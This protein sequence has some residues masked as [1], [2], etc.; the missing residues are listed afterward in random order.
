MAEKMSRLH[1]IQEHE[2]EIDWIFSE[3]K[4]LQE[5]GGCNHGGPIC[6]LIPQWCSV[7]EQEATCTNWNSGGSIWLGSSS[8]WGWPC[9]QPGWPV[10]LWISN[11]WNIQNLTDTEHSPVQPGLPPHAWEVSLDK[12]ISRGPFQSLQ[13]CDSVK[14]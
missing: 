3:T 12:K 6:V 1:S 11:P 10:K 4:Q 9:T 2:K 5:S 13:F 7:T 14:R 8:L